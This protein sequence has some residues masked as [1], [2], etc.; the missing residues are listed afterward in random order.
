MSHF[1]Y[2]YAECHYAKWHY[3]ECRGTHN[4]AFQNDHPCHFVIL[5]HLARSLNAN[6][7]AM[8]LGKVDRITGKDIKVKSS[9]PAAP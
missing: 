4:R 5:G 8:G 1:I 7:T 2:C 6:A 9:N 3:T